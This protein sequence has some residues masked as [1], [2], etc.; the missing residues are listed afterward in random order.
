M[1]KHKS[2][3]LMGKSYPAQKLQILIKLVLNFC[4]S[5]YTFSEICLY[6]VYSINFKFIP[7]VS[8]NYLNEPTLFSQY[9]LSE[10]IMPLHTYSA[11]KPEL[12]PI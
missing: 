3:V 2:K 4:A 7:E 1:R 5:Y 9:Y 10:Q 6:F 11:S 12:T 8:V